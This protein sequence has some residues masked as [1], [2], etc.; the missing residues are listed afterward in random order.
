MNLKTILTL[1]VTILILTLIAGCL[2]EDPEP[3][4]YVEQSAEIPVATLT[5][6]V[7]VIPAITPTSVST[8]IIITP[9]EFLIN[10]II[11]N[12][13]AN[14]GYYNLI[15]NRSEMHTSGNMA[16]EQAQYI[17][18]N[19]NYSSGIVVL[20]ETQGNSGF[21]QTWVIINNTTYIID[22]R[23]NQYWI[24]EDHNVEFDSTY[25]INHIPL[26]KGIEL[27]KSSNDYF[28]GLYN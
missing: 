6:K 12:D 5:P 13:P 17:I 2:T 11:Q 19:Y 3:Y 23:T 20:A 18:D 22:S 7:T 26:K 25:K 1:T 28:C 8:T 9:I 21:A 16:C 4:V 14:K 15:G 10:D 27:I 24:E